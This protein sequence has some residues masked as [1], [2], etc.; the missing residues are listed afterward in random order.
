MTLGTDIAAALSRGLGFVIAA[1]DEQGAWTD[2]ALPPG[3]S[4]D[5][6]TAHVALRL[7]SL[8]PPDRAA[9]DEPLVRAAHWLLSRRSAGGGWGYNR[10][11]EPPGACTFLARHQQPDGGFA[12]FAPDSFTGSWGLSHPEITPVALLALRAHPSGLPQDN[13]ARGVAWLQRARRPDGL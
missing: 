6:T 1:Q 8:G 7:S 10:A 5:W 2:W 11:V 4:P 13:L 9:L 3:P 12:T